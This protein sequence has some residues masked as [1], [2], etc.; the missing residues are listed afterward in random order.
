MHA[1]LV[2]MLAAALLAGCQYFRGAP[3]S[4]LA[5]LQPTRGHSATGRFEFLQ[6]GPRVRVQAFVQGLAPGSEH[7]VHVHEVGDCSAPDAASAKG[8]FNPYGKPH[9]HYTALERHAGDL[10]PLKADSRGRAEYV[11][12]LDIIS[13][14]GGPADIVGRS[15]VVHANPD[16]F[17]TQP[18]GNAGARIACGVIRKTPD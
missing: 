18:A 5:E 14:T 2:T 1:S 9:A 12:E 7:G 11:A 10:P 8:H 6:V 16:D 13:L 3:G 17:R 4:A 15:V